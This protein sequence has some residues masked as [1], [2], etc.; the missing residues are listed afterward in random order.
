MPQAR[1]YQS[2]AERQRAYRQ[3]HQQPVTEPAVVQPEP[4]RSL[5]PAPAISS[6]PAQARWN[7]L[8][9]QAGTTLKV[10]HGEME[11][12]FQDRSESWQE[13]ERGEAFQEKK[14]ALEEVIGALEE[15]AADYFTTS[16]AEKT[17]ARN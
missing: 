4:V 8:V 6:I 7:A 16:G 17:D 14:D 5:P 10:V 9:H 13:G 2:G 3:R 15:L 1:R 11:S 12:Y